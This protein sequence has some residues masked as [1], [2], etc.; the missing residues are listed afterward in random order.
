MNTGLEELKNLSEI[1]KI[2]SYTNILNESKQFCED[3]EKLI[4]ET[5]KN[6]INIANSNNQIIQ[7]QL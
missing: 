5:A 1:D 2:N 6:Q 7:T 3:C 4:L